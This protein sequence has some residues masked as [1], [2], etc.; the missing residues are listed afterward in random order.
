MNAVS[1]APLPTVIRHGIRYFD[2]GELEDGSDGAPSVV[3]LHG[4]GN[5]LQFWVRVAPLLGRAARVVALDI[6]GF[7]G[8]LAPESNDLGGY[9]DRINKLLHDLELGRYHLA[10]HS[11]GAVVAGRLAVDAPHA[12]ASL[13]LVA[14]MPFS[15]FRAIR[16]L[17]S[18]LHEPAVSFNVLCQFV[19]GMVPVGVLGSRLLTSSR[20]AKRVALWPFVHDASAVSDDVL[21]LLLKET[22]GLSVLRAGVL[23][24][25]GAFDDLFPVPS[26]PVRVVRGEH[27]RL[28]TTADVDETVQ[29]YD[30]VDVVAV[31]ACGHWPLLE[32]PDVLVDYITSFM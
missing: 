18:A 13:L 27:D 29:R 6:P 22:G 3:L 9:T 7:G 8:S 19:G 12:V 14:A 30:A 15:G 17:R 28:V 4:L 11:M 10:G 26:V 20:L 24:H 23:A 1:A 25:R 5:T 31:R 21:A 16:S 2:S 32:K